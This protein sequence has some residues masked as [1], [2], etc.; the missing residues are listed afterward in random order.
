MAKPVGSM[1][2]FLEG[3]REQEQKM[4]AERATHVREATD[5]LDLFAAKKVEDMTLFEIS[6]QLMLPPRD[7]RKF[8]DELAR[9]RLVSIE[10]TKEGNDLVTLT[11]RGKLYIEE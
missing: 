8:V 3:Y 6:S 1:G 2:P 10:P 9:R 11:K 7:T 4:S 5:I